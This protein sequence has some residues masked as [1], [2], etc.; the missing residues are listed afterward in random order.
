MLIE[1]QRPQRATVV[2]P[3][4]GEDEGFGTVVSEPVAPSYVSI[5]PEYIFSFMESERHPGV[6]VIKGPDGRGI[7]VAGSYADVKAKLAAAG[8]ATPN[9]E[10]SETVQ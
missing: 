8:W 10:S 7:L 5:N 2:T 9:A 6:S 4:S 3:D 1:F